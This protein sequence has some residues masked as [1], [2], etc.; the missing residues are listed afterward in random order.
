LT[1]IYACRGIDLWCHKIYQA[2][3]DAL[4]ER[5][6]PDSRAIFEV[7]GTDFKAANP[8][9]TTELSSLLAVQEVGKGVVSDGASVGVSV[10]I[11]N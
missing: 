11:A 6:T 9:L 3:H 5:T 7:L 8:F 1:D 2:T 10:S 4:R